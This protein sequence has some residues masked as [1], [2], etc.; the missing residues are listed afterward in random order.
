MFTD[1]RDIKSSKT[2]RI[3]KCIYC[4]C[5]T[6]FYCSPNI[7]GKLHSSRCCLKVFAYL[8][9]YLKT[10]VYLNLVIQ[11]LVL[12]KESFPGVNWG[13]F[14]FEKSRCL[15]WELNPNL[16]KFSSFFCLLFPNYSVSCVGLWVLVP[17]LIDLCIVNAIL[18]RATN[19]C[20]QK[21]WIS[22]ISRSPLSFHFF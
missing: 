3:S 5:N 2:L 18:L 7:K 6:I 17:M 11:M 9:H 1:G 14:C 21:N 15:F 4:L 22:S 20:S 12:Q 13:S 19:K 8:R 16:I 10:R